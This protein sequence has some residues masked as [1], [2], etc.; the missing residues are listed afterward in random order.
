[1]RDG[2]ERARIGPAVHGADADDE[3]EGAP[4]HGPVVDP[5]E[6]RVAAAVVVT[7]RAEEIDAVDGDADRPEREERECER[8]RR[9]PDHLS[10]PSQASEA[11]ESPRGGEQECAA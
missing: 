7:A 9:E 2:G 5:A 1:E 6:D 8:R 3:E 11:A 10:R 4:G